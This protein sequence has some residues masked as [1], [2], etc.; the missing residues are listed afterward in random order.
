M[1]TGGRVCASDARGRR[2]R[3]RGGAGRSA[4]RR[5]AS[6]V[7]ARGA[8]VCR[9][10]SPRPGCQTVQLCATTADPAHLIYSHCVYATHRRRI[11]IARPRLPSATV[12][13]A[14]FDRL[15]IH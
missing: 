14:T 9:A 8:R 15:T 12:I 11:N 3:G 7:L 1:L 5:R 13:T 10:P 4:R 6:D 2:R